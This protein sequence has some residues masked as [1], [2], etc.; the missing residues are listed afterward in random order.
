MADVAI[1][2]WAGF[3]DPG[4]DVFFFS[5]VDGA[6]LCH[7]G[8]DSTSIKFGASVEGG[9]DSDHDGR[10][11]L[12]A[13]DPWNQ[14]NGAA[15]GSATQIRLGELILD[16]TPRLV[17][18]NEIFI[19]LSLIGGPTGNPAGLFLIDLNG[20]TQCTLLQLGTF[21]AVRRWA[22]IV[23]MPAP[24]SG[25]VLTLRA[26]AIDANGRAIASNDETITFR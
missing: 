10:L 15:A 8:G 17:D 23:Y 25:N 3:D 20:A 26:Y 4:G 13:G 16:A 18:P 24:L 12:V 6:L 19:Q 5:G 22:Q 7:V 21:D 14:T 9:I 11:D 2:D 1:S